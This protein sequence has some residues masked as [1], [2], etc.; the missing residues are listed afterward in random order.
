MTCLFDDGPDYGTNLNFTDDNTAQITFTQGFSFPFYGGKYTSV[1]INSNGN[2]TFGGGS[3]SFIPSV[4]AFINGLP[5]IAPYWIDLNPSYAGSGGGVF[6]KQLPDRFIVSYINLP[7]YFGPLHPAINTFQIVLYSS[8]MIGFGYQTLDNNLPAGDAGP[9]FPLVGIASG[10]GGPSQI[11]QYN[12]PT[13][14]SITLSGTSPQGQ[15]NET[16]LF[17]L[18]NGEDYTLLDKVVPFCCT[19]TIPRGF[20]LDLSRKLEAALAMPKKDCLNCIVEPMTVSTAIPAPCS[21]GSIVCFIEVK[22]LRVI[23]TLNIKSSVPIKGIYNRTTSYVGCSSTVCFN[24]IL[25]IHCNNKKVACVDASFFDEA[26]VQNL[27]IS[28]LI[29]T[30]CNGDK[31]YELRG[32]VKLLPC[33]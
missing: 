9:S 30:T 4:S 22:A 12:P 3:T 20:E 16:Q 23:G 26:T 2:L 6:Y 27:T 7:Y 21:C 17:W 29:T 19:I 10:S 15:L 11:F 1:F 13:N 33:C 28:D 24:K 32:I 8:G 31:I 18:Y 5:R 14:P 25:C